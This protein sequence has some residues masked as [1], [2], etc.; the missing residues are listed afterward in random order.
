MNESVNEKRKLKRQK[1]DSKKKCFVEISLPVPRGTVIKKEVIDLSEA[2]L[3]FI[4]PS[5]EGY[6]MPGTPLKDVNIITDD[7]SQKKSAVEVIY[8]KEIMREGGVDYRI[9]IQFKDGV[10]GSKQ[11][12]G[13]ASHLHNRPLRFDMNEFGHVTQLVKFGDSENKEIVGDVINF[14]EYGIAFAVEEPNFV[15]ASSQVIHDFMIIFNNKVIFKGNITIVDVTE[16]D[17]KLEVRANFMQTIFDVQKIFTLVKKVSVKGEIASYVGQLIN[18]RKKINKKYSVL[19]NDMRYF[20]ENLKTK[21][22]A[23][24]NDLKKDPQ[25]NESEAGIE[26]LEAIRKPICKYVFDKFI[27]LNKLMLSFNAEENLLH[28]HY[29]QN[30]LHPL[31]LMSS[32][33]SRAYTKPLGYAG[34][35]EVS[36]MIYRNSYEGETLFSKFIHKLSINFPVAQ[37][38]RNRVSIIIDFINDYIKEKEHACDIKI[39]SIGSGPGKEVEVFMKKTNRNTACTYTLVDFDPNALTYCQGSLLKLKAKLKH[40]IK[41]NFL[42]MTIR[43]VLKK[44]NEIEMLANQDIIYLFGFFDY[45]PSEHCKLF[46]KVLYKN[47]KQGGKLIISNVHVQ[48]EFRIALEHGA[49]WYLYHRSEQEVRELADGIK[50]NKKVD[51]SFDKT[52]VNIFLNI[53]K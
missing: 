26:I 52:K 43:Q 40:E 20:L 42:S 46:L 41:L 29:F 19:I 35:Y 15:L 6:F 45:I 17:D 11:P 30:Q 50:G 36:N 28:K 53:T 27:K 48:N 32:F 25:I 7:N 49:D 24:E 47:I 10:H 51:I 3:S 21:L 38:H 33:N 34:D 37:A 39:L 14:S 9:G 44:I 13:S 16:K 1:T 5:E 18:H 23:V 31:Y 8:L 2:G 4:I 22:D 12:L